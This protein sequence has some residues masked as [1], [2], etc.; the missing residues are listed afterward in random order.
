MNRPVNFSKDNVAIQWNYVK[1]NFRDMGILSEYVESFE[2]R[3]HKAVEKLIQGDIYQEFREQIRADRYERNDIRK[4]RRKGEYE[5][6]LTTTF[7]CSKIKIP[8]T[9]E[10]MKIRYSLFEKY[11]RRQKKFDQ[12]IVISMIL[13]FST[14]KQHK[15]FKEF[16]GDAVSHGTASRLMKILDESLTEFRTKRIEDKYKYLLIDGIWVHLKEASGVKKRPII[17][18][19]GVGLDNTKEILAF[20]LTT[21]ESEAAVTPVLND[22]YRRGLEGKNLKVIAS[23]GAKGIKAAIEMVYPY[24]K[25]QLCST[26]KLRNLC[27]N[28][29]Q[30]KKHRKEILNDASRIYQSETR[31]EAVIRFGKFCDKWEPIERKAVKHF[32]K[33]FSKTLTFYEYAEDRRFISTTNHLERDLEEIR[34]RIKTQGCFKNERSVDL[35][36]YGILKYSERIKEPKGLS[37]SIMREK[38]RELEYESVQNS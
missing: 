34:R 3:A 32:S 21:G 15:F 30:K 17:V 33:D 36:V 22:L 19:L 5:R 4:D 29:E 28:I 18:I 9:R 2:K 8:R 13:G 23:D 35:W 10:G 12:M 6:F 37:A 27:G 26:H 7:G 25:W 38:T 31:K 16:I 11:Q 1:R 20:K 24:A 14:R